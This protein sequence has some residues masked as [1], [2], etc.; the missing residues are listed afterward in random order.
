M[1][2]SALIKKKAEEL[3]ATLCGIGAIYDEPDFQRDPKND[4]AECKMY[5]WFW[6]CGAKGAL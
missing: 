1:L 4:S 2:T 5:Y 3:G 6:L